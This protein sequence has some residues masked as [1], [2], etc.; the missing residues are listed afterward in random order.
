MMISALQSR[1]FGLGMALSDNKLKRINEKRKGENYMDE[2]AAKKRN[3]SPFKK[4]LST[5]N[6]FYIEFEYG[7]NKE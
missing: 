7:A 4:A 5:S 6:P 3:G 2:D 1:E